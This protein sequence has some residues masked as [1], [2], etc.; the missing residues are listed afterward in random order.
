MLSVE[1]NLMAASDPDINRLSNSLA[2]T[3][4]VNSLEMELTTNANLEAQSVDFK[5]EMNMIVEDLSGDSKCKITI[6]KFGQHQEFYLAIKDGKANMYIKD[7]SGKY[8]VKSL[9]VSQLSEINFTNS[10]NSYSEIINSDP[11]IVK[12][13]SENRYLLNIPKEKMADYYR[14]ITGKNF[15]VDI[16]FETLIIEFIIGDDGYIQNVNL[17]TG[18]NSISISMNTRYFN[19]NKRFNIILPEIP[20]KN[21][22]SN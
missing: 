7:I 20:N 5:M 2:Q 12:K 14:K 3:S 17:S 1:T 9:D 4:N 15:P 11:E 8:S 22:E 10:F 16:D 13:T 19:Y 6:D 21:P 18:V